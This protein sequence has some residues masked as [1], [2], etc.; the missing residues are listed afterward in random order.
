MIQL[1]F[2]AVSAILV[3]G[4]FIAM[5]VHAEK[6]EL[7]YHVYPVAMTIVGSITAFITAG[8]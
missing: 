7:Y 1:V 4:G 6:G 8:M 5:V 3:F 2:L